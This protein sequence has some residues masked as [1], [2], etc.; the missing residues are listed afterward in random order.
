M[1]RR[2]RYYLAALILCVAG[3]SVLRGSLE[4]KLV[5]P[6]SATQG[7]AGATLPPSPDYEL[8]PLQTS[9]GT[10][11]VAEFGSA[12]GIDGKSEAAAGH[13]PTVI[14]FYGNGACAANMA[15]EFWRFRQMGVNIIMPDYPGYGMS[16]GRPSERGFYAAA[17]AVY[18]YVAQRPGIDRDRIA[19]V[20]WSMGGAVAIDLACRR[21][22]AALETISAFTSLPAVA[23]TVAP[24]LPVKWILRSRFDNLAK[25][26]SIT[27]PILIAHGRLDQIVPPEMAGQLA[28][29]TQSGV[30][31]FMIEGAGHNDV[32]DVGGLP[33]WEAM[34]AELFGAR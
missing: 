21:K 17:D 27:C 25:I 14:F 15:V 24:W 22:V 18:D 7:L 4:T 12:L 23:H 8:I 13:A 34:R 1:R 28:A 30:K 5:F 31:A 6:G 3:I 2:Q 32:F 33:L 16:G 11:I 26:H 19:V 10:R 20:G 9:D 29:A